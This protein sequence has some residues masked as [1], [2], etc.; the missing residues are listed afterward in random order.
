MLNLY[1]HSLFIVEL[2][3]IDTYVGCV[4]DCNTNIVKEVYKSS[5]IKYWMWHI[6]LDL[7]LDSAPKESGGLCTYLA[8]MLTVTLLSC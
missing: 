5:S 4:N 6:K 2:R 1:S 7:Q 8:A 3:Y